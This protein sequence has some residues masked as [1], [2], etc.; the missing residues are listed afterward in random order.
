MANMTPMMR[1]YLEMKEKYPGMILFFRLGDFYEMFFDDAKLVSRELELTLTGKNCGMAER[2]PMCGVPFHSAETYINRLIEKGYKVAICEQMEDPAT[3]KGLVRRDVI[4]VVTPGTVIEQSMLDERRNSYLLS[5]C[6][7]A[8]R[9]GLAFADVS[10]GEFFV[11]EIAKASVRLEDELVRIMPK[12]IIANS[13][14]PSGVTSLA[15]DVQESTRYQFAR[16]KAALIAHFQVQSLEALG[17]AELK[18]GVRAAGALMKYLEET[19]KN[20]LEHM[21]GITQYHDQRYMMLDHTAR[22]NLELTE[23]MRSRQKQGSLLGIL[24]YTCTAMGGRMLRSFIEQPLAVKEEIDA[25]LDAVQALCGQDMAVDRLREELAQ[26]YDVERLLS[27]ISYKNITAKDCLALRDSLSRVPFVRDTLQGIA[28]GGLL[29]GLLEQI[30]PLEDV[31][32]RLTRAIDPDAPALMS[33]GHYIRDGYSE[34]LDKLRE[35]SKNGHQWIAD[36][37]AKER[38]LTKIKNLKIQYNKVFGYYIEVTKSN[39]DQVPY[40]YTRK[41]TLANCERYMTPELHE[42]EETVLGAQEKALRLEQ[43][44]FVE[45][46]DF[47]SSQIPRIQRTAEGLKTLD[48]LVSLAVAAVRNRYVRP[49]ITQDGTLDI[50][51]GRHPVVEAGM[52]G[53]EQFVPNSTRMDT[54]ENRML[55]ITGPNMAG[56]STYMRQV[57]LITLMAHMGS[58]VPADSARIGIVDRIF[59]RV[60]AS[61]DLASGQSTFMV[62]M[63]EMAHILRSATPHSLIV[64]DEIGRGTSTFDGLSIAWAVVEY[65]V[66]PK[67]IGAKTL[68]ATHYHELSE[69]EGRLQGVVNYRISVREHGEEVIFLRK[70]ERGGAD[71]SFGIH[72]ASLAGLPRP[73]IMR[74]HE[75]LAR[76]ETNDVNQ[77]SIGQNILGEQDKKPK[78][79][80]LFESPAMDLVEELRTLDVM[81]MTPIEALNTLFTLREKARKV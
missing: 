65:L 33:D 28:G 26:V 10:T 32:D 42:I 12:E 14:L 77:V 7:D 74:A 47:L 66:D 37:E 30:T 6:M 27:R 39:Y 16:A 64:L 70:I 58:F 52:H 54:Q 71:R 76:L 43:A 48:A 35:A 53:D 15:V 80:T 21:T 36:L 73:V 1:Q 68:F 55:I 56:K 57:A 67:K 78:Q 2:A 51:N 41:Q 46:R 29:A 61:D 31:V 81:A 60:G 44:L 62:E 19:Q 11:Y 9:A 3:A 18:L 25:R 34:E 79:V 49:E 50:Q 8:D 17:I 69:L 24:D 45:I 40:R 4:R 72:V 20:A 22:R 5:V 63:N 59:T 23:T 13:E 75:I 38:E